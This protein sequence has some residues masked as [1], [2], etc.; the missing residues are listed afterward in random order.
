MSEGSAAPIVGL[1]VD[2][3]A[4]TRIALKVIAAKTGTTVRALVA[5]G[6]ICILEEGGETP[7]GELRNIASVG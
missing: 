6:L 7:S 3:D 4:P 1:K 2:V 5:R